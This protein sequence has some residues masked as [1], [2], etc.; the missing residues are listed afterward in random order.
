VGAIITAWIAAVYGH[1]HGS[2]GHHRLTGTHIPLQ[3][4]VHLPSG[5]NVALDFTKC[6]F[7]S[8]GKFKGST[9]LKNGWYMDV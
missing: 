7:L 3:Q 4:A 5:T 1:E 9:S 2:D 8:P 6:R